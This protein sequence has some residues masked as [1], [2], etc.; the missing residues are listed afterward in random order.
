MENVPSIGELRLNAHL[1]MRGGGGK[2]HQCTLRCDVP[3]QGKVERAALER[4]GSLQ[5]IASQ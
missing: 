1:P 4:I 5:G 3:K 2:F